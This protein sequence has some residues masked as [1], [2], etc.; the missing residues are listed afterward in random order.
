MKYSIRDKYKFIIQ[1]FSEHN[2]QAETELHYE[3]TFHLLVA[4]ILSAQCT[5]KRDRKSVV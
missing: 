2:P 1:Y 5:D 3:S 4:V